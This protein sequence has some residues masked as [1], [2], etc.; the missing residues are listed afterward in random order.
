MR[1]ILGLLF[2]VFISLTSCS[3]RDNGIVIS[4][5]FTDEQWAR[6]DY[7][8]GNIDIDKT[9]EKYDV[10]M[11]VAV[12]DIFPNIYENHQDN[13]TLSVNLTIINPDNNGMRS[14]NYNFNLKDKDGNWKS[15]NVNGYYIFKL[16]MISEMTFT[17]KG[18]YKFKLENKYSKDPLYGIKSLTI[19]CI[20]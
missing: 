13:S 16:P 20:N 10:V 11:E 12:S 9:S 8:E 3:S 2:A 15:E 7:L 4:K 5:E 18:T 19:R 14:R 17:E 1:F 6:F